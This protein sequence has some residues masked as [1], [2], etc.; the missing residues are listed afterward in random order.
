MMSTAS[1]GVPFYSSA[2]FSKNKPQFGNNHHKKK[3]KKPNLISDDI[4]VVL[5]TMKKTNTIWS[6]S[7]FS[8]KAQPYKYP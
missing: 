4:I 1:L 6:V 8:A 7:I 3:S 2:S 5:Q